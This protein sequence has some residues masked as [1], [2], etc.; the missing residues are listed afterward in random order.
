[1]KPLVFTRPAQVLHNGH[2]YVCCPSCRK[3]TADGEPASVTDEKPA[4][5]SAG[6]CGPVD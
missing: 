5:D 4:R 2:R 6:H 1:M 3:A